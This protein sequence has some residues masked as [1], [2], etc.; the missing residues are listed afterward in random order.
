MINRLDPL[1][2]DVFGPLAHRARLGTI[3]PGDAVILTGDFGVVT[4]TQRSITER[5]IQLGVKI[6]F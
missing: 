3:V 4:S 2:D 6:I 5:Q 1:R